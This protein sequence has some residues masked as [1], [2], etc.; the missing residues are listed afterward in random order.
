MKSALATFVALAAFA[1]ASFA[2][3][4]EH[5]LG[6]HPAVLVKRAEAKQTYDYQ[7]QFYPHPAWLYLASEAPHPMMD[8]P[9]VIV[10]KRE[11][12]AA[13]GRSAAVAVQAQVGTT[14]R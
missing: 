14:V 2:Q 6:E 13:A 8:H 7:A 1:T 12:E 3:E 9:A 4:A 10:A 11:R 5:R